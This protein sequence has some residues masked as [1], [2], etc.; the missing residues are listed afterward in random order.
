MNRHLE[1]LT[2]VCLILSSAILTGC[3]KQSDAVMRITELEGKVTTKPSDSD[4]FVS[5]VIDQ[6]L[7]S[8]DVIVTDEASKAG[9]EFIE[10]KSKVKLG[11]NTFL[12]IHS[13]S[14]KEL[15]Q[16]KGIAIYQIDKQ[17]QQLKVQTPQ[18]VATVL[19]TVFRID[20]TDL[21][22]IV[23]VKEGKVAFS[24]K[25]GSQVTING[26]QRYATGHSDNIVLPVDADEIEMMFC[27]PDPFAQTISLPANNQLLPGKL[28]V[29]PVLGDDEILT[30]AENKPSESSFIS[31]G[32]DEPIF[33]KQ[34]EQ[35]SIFV[36][37]F[38]SII[39]AGPVSIKQN[40]NNAN[41]IAGHALFDIS[42]NNPDKQFF[43]KT[44]DV[45]I[46]AGD[47]IFGVEKNATSTKIVILSGNL[48]ITC[49]DCDYH[50]P[51]SYTAEISATGISKKLTS[52]D[53]HAYWS[54]FPENLAM[55]TTE[56][57][58]TI[59]NTTESAAPSTLSPQELLNK[60]DIEQPR[61]E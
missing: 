32:S 23:T 36:T 21:E 27:S 24:S 2:L 13:F 53:E 59:E 5:A 10:D 33:L 6:K 40:E 56:A 60:I 42:S 16:I 19:G 39:L 35:K 57:A 47:A 8:G 58:E 44:E 11:K 26:G 41:L 51:Y 30:G 37:D 31:P 38:G 55:P 4:A 49:N 15:R 50:L 48:A 7:M 9:L 61:E 54:D 3:C 46:R 17:K 14:V 34:Y 20:V 18:G 1:I 12:E 45:T 52:Q 29:D 43:I 22:T 28:L 25:S